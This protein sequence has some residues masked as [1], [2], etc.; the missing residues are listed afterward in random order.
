MINSIYK[1]VITDAHVKIEKKYEKLG[2]FA[3][4]KIC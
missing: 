1:Y 4:Q 3:D 2:K